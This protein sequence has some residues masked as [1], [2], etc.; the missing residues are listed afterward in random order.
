MEFI[1]GQTL[2]KIIGKEVGPIPY[3]KVL[4]LFTQILEEISYA[5]RQ[6]VVHPDLNPIN[7]ILTPE[8][9][10]K[11]TDSGI[12]GKKSQTQ[13]PKTGTK[14]GTLFYKSLE[15]LRGENVD[16]QS[17]IYSLGIILY[18]MLAGRL[19]FDKYEKMSDFTLMNKIVSEKLDDPREF[20]PHIPEWLV[21]IIHKATAKE[22][23][24]RIKT[25][26]SF[27][28]LLKT[29]KETFEK[30]VQEELEKEKRLLKERED[31]EKKAQEKILTVRQLKREK[32]I[33]RPTEQEP[34]VK[35]PNKGKAKSIKGR[36]KKIVVILYL[37]F[38]IAVASASFL[39]IYDNKT[40]D[41]EW[42]TENL[43]IAYYRNG[44][45][46]PEVTDPKKWAKLKTGAWCYYDN[47][48]ENGKE[49]GKLYNWYAVNDPRG[50]APEGWH[51]PTIE[52]L[53]KA[54][55]NDGDALKAMGYGSG[56]NTSGFSALLAGYRD[57]V[58]YFY[59]LGYVPYFWSSTEY[60]TV[61]AY[62]LV[63]P[64]HD[65]NVTLSHNSKAYGFSVRYIK[66][67]KKLVLIQ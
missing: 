45:S 11:I 58:G 3:E 41:S 7:I 15:Q 31:S 33:T 61:S 62:D 34:S 25:A 53:T 60:D 59:D 22:K 51:I 20:Y 38:C 21:N 4:P 8:N 52:E 48:P 64:Y 56:K 39:I 28:S 55:N 44:D 40:I 14:R 43:N 5:H 36:K 46:I 30:Q 57:S 65:S 37:V 19:P 32:E 54:V 49:Y 2:N 13:T 66:D 35:E 67:K 29:G 50:L 9:K 1:E 12:T 24:E 10:I 47:E 6:G 42:M 23:S 16:K 26:D 63:L 17:D 27:I 18:E